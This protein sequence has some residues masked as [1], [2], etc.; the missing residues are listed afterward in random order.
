MEDSLYEI[1]SIRRFG[2]L[3]LSDRFPDESITL[4][5]RHLL[6]RYK[7]GQ[8]LFNEINKHL[9]IQALMLGEGSVVDALH[10][11]LCFHSMAHRPT[12]NLA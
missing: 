5:F 6:E 9:T 4:N 7:L 1:E 2:G 8:T 3:R 12:N 11:E 10:Y